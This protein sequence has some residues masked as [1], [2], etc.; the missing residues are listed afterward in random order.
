[1]G[2]LLKY[3]GAMG[4]TAQFNC[5]PSLKLVPARHAHEYLGVNGPTG[6]GFLK[7]KK[8]I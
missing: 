7:T 5:S 4:K 8:L 1:M 2:C 3:A 6:V